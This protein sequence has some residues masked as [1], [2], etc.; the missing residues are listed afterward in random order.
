MKGLLGSEF[1]LQCY[2]E[3]SEGLERSLHELVFIG[4]LEG[5][6]VFGRTPQ[7]GQV[8]HVG[9]KHIA[10]QVTCNTGSWEQVEGEADRLLE[11][12]VLPGTDGSGDL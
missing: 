11:F 12:S 1:T 3:K 5:G 8:I 9:A 7:G 6:Q 2:V 4:V 10:G